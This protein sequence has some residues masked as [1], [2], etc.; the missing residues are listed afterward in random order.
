MPWKALIQ[1]GGSLLGGLF[2]KKKQSTT[3]EIDYVRLRENAEAA[4]FNPLTALRAGGGA[5]FTT[6]H[7][8]ALASGQFIADAM[9]GLGNYAA[10]IDPMRDATAKLEHEIKQATLANIQADT[11]ARLRASIG[12]VPV[13]TGARNVNVS[14]PLAA[15]AGAAR[16]PTVETPT[17]TNPF[18]T[19]GG[20]HVNPGWPD[21][22]AAEERWGDFGGSI[23][24]LGLGVVDGIYNARRSRAA[25]DDYWR[26]RV[27]G[28]L[29]ERSEAA[30]KRAREREQRLRRG[31]ARN[32]RDLGFPAHW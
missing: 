5:G 28:A 32:A 18:P 10:S 22:A 11:A 16:T 1:V 12:G 23:Y 17:L 6:T 15:N 27:A 14:S 24:G 9:G 8:P 29:S 20:L 4:G 7:H 30:K 21:A 13:S 19:A 25:L 31:A 26:P 2:G 3:S